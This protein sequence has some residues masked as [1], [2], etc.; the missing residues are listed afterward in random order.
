MQKLTIDDVEQMS[1]AYMAALDSIPK[2]NSEFQTLI[3][4]TSHVQPQRTRRAV[5]MEIGSLEAALHENAQR[6][7]CL[8]ADMRIRER[9][10]KRIKREIE[11]MRKDGK[12]EDDIADKEDE[13]IKLLAENERDAHTL[14]RT[15]SLANDAVIKLEKLIQHFNTLP[16]VSREEFEKL[17][18]GYFLQRLLLEAALQYAMDGRVHSGTLDSLLKLPMQINGEEAVRSL[19]VGEVHTMVLDTLNDHGVEARLPHHLP[20]LCSKNPHGNC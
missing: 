10:I 13:I 1:P 11:D 17:E 18:A 4:G 2:G 16:D 7:K 14:K 12:P 9:Q 20:K 8:D 6:Y 3:L 15:K 5:L 19:T